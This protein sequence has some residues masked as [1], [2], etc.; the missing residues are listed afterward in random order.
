MRKP[1]TFTQTSCNFE[2]ELRK[3]EGVF[4]SSFGQVQPVTEYIGGEKY[5]GDYTVTPAMKAQTLPTMNKVLT[6][7]VII[8]PIPFYEV[9]NPGGGKT[10]Y[11]AQTPEKE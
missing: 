6:E 3:Q 7:N 8:S 5:E 9:S 11:I 4:T 1:I 2:I 10:V